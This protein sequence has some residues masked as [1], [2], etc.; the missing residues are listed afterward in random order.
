MKKTLSLILALVLCLSLCACGGGNDTPKT[1][2]ALTEAPTEAPTE[3]TEAQLS[4]E[5]LITNAITTD[6]FTLQSAVY[7]NKV[8]AK[9]DYCNKPIV[10]TGKAIKVEDDYVVMSEGQVSVYAF[11]SVDDLVKIKTQTNIS[12]VGIISDIQDEDSNWGGMTFNF[13]TYIMDLAY[14]IEE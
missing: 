9:Q 5:E 2:E 10:V 12:V 13:P 14:L 6:I 8:K 4:K 3:A 1:T 7:Q 11:L